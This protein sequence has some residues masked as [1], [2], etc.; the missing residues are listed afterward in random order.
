MRDRFDEYREGRRTLGTSADFPLDVRDEGYWATRPRGPKGWQR[1]DERIHDEVCERIAHAPG[2]DASD[3]S[4][5]VS[6]GQV[7][8]EGTVPQRAMK[9]RIEDEI[10]GCAG[11]RDVDNRIK[12]QTGEWPSQRAE[13]SD[14]RPGS[15]LLDLFGMQSGTRV[16]ELMTRDVQTVSADDTLQHAAELMK[17]LDV[18]VLPVCDGDRLRGIVTDRDIAVRA[19]A[20]G[21]DPATATVSQAMTSQVHWC[22]QD[23]PIDAV[24]ERMRNL[25]VRRIPVLD[26]DRRLVGIVA[27]ADVA[28]RQGAS[29][30]EPALQ[31]ISQP[32]RSSRRTRRAV[33][34]I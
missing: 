29:V 3:V 1:S 20:Q 11:V 21:Q 33:I 30:A 15:L 5:S 10:V 25:Q 6:G 26:R 22:D 2:I 24:L 17:Q 9:Y 23:D 7:R 12:V 16:R 8:L 34:G 28:L 18:G 13:R 27:L 4:V 32:T 14:A 19:V 31:D